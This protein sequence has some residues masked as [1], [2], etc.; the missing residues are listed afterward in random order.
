MLQ[1]LS[2]KE[3]LGSQQ[4]YESMTAKVA[5]GFAGEW[6][7]RGRVPFSQIVK[8]MGQFSGAEHPTLV[9]LVFQTIAKEERHTCGKL[10]AANQR[11][12]A[13]QQRCMQ[14]AK[15][16][17]V[18]QLSFA[19]FSQPIGATLPTMIRRSL[20]AP[21]TKWVSARRPQS[22]NGL[23]P[24]LAGEKLLLIA[25]YIGIAIPLHTSLVAGGSS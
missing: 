17:Q 7:A 25:A 11:Y 20:L 16:A 5:A 9:L 12:T 6:S 1:T 19:C 22:S 4:G 8:P 14:T 18:R 3:G 23:S 2:Q 15:F 21:S 10:F 24:I 13:G